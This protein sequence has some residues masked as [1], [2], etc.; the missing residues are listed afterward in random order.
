M[1]SPDMQIWMQLRREGNKSGNQA[2]ISTHFL[3]DFPSLQLAQKRLYEKIED[4][5]L[6]APF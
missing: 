6:F 4:F 3:T 2:P 5:F 1:I